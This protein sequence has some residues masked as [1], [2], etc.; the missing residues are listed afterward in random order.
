MIA[1]NTSPYFCNIAMTE[2]DFRKELTQLKVPVLIL[3]GTKDASAP[4]PLTGARTVS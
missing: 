1:P 2:T 3:H 4:L